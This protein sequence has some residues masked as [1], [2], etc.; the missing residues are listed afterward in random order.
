MN[1]TKINSCEKACKKMMYLR[2]TMMII[3]L[4]FVFL[5]L[6]ITSAKADPL[7]AVT[8]GVTLNRMMDQLQQAIESA[9]NAGLN[10]EIGAGRE[11][12]I[13]I[14]NA[15]NAYDKSLSLTMRQSG[16]RC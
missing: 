12:S 13:A 3:A 6:P 14:A 16:G 2:K 5:Q 1:S 11:I 15:Q 9:K 10:L 8:I 4:L 7:T